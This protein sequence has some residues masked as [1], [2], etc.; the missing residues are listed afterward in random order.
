MIRRETRLLTV[1]LGACLLAPVFLRAEIQ[2]NRNDD[3]RLLL[4]KENAHPSD[5][6]KIADAPL[7][8]IPAM[9]VAPLPAPE[10]LA[11]AQAEVLRAPEA[12]RNWAALAQA[13]YAA[14]DYGKSLAA[15]QQMRT[16]A[17]ARNEPLPLAADELFAKCKRAADALTLLE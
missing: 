11:Q 10:P 17:T 16:A 2:T 14:G 3:S 12:W 15:A 13:R 9:R 6:P 8:E 1:A 4:R 7:P 5:A